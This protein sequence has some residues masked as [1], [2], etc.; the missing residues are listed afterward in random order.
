VSITAEPKALA[1]RL[2]D[3]GRE[4]EAGIAGRLARAKAYA[5]AG[6]DVIVV[7]NDGAPSEGVA[8]LVAAIRPFVTPRP[9]SRSAE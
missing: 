6:A 9:G 4:D 5:V 8:Q 7:R 3:R 1:E 2:R